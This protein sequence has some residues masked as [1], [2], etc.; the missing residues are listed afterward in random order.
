MV[1][2]K[3]TKELSIIDKI[4]PALT[5]INIPKIVDEKSMINATEILSQANKYLKDLVAD[6]ETM[7]KP[8]NESL[9][10]IRAKYKPLEIKLEGIIANIRNSMTSYQTEQIHLQ[11]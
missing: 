11:K 3:P 6:K 4:T 2:K 1:T 9:K 10:V 5:S 8:I 7:T